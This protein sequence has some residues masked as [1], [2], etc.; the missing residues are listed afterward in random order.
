[1]LRELQTRP[2]QLWDSV[3]QMLW[4]QDEPVHTMTAAVGY[5]LMKLVASHGIR[6][7]LNGQGAD[8]TIG[9]Y[10]SYFS[11]YWR[12]LLGRRR[13]LQ[14]CAEAKAFAKVHGGNPA[15]YVTET[16]LRLLAISLH[17]NPLY[18]A[19]AERSYARRVQRHSWFTSDF[20]AQFPRTV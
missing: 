1:E 20:A 15:G 5:H 6:V 3:R 7:V 18:R 11:D 13:W 12:E 2:R 17:Q 8:E 19:F 16:A 14:A 9:G 10:F 4:Y